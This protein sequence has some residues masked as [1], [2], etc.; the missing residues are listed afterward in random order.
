M[1]SSCGVKND[2]IVEVTPCGFVARAK[3]IIDPKTHGL[4]VELVERQ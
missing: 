3:M 4:D 1:S 2:T